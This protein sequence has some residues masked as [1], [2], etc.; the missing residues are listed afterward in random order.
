M[1]AGQPHDMTTKPATPAMPAQTSVGKSRAS[2]KQ[3]DLNCTISNRER[4]LQ[5]SA[6]ESEWLSA[7]V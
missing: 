5:K 6:A 7:I 2:D 1:G 3:Q 4:G